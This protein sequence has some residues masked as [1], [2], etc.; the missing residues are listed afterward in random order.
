MKLNLACKRFQKL[1]NDRDVR[2]LS[3]QEESF[4]AQHRRDCEECRSFEVSSDDVL[5]VLRSATLEPEISIGFEDRV[6]RKLKLQT[7]RESLSYW[8]PA[9]VGA[10]IACV[11][12][13]ATLQIAATPVQLN[14]AKLPV[15]EAK[16]ELGPERPMPELILSEKPRLNQ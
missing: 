12:I 2:D 3:D 9:L 6:I 1:W 13:V 8:T 7:M 4:V 16:L 14:K 5:S 11:A 15:G 10:G